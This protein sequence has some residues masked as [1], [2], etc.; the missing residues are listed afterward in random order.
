VLEAD[1]N[2]DPISDLGDPSVLDHLWRRRRA[3]DDD[4]Q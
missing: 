3:I 2:R 4:L 1:D